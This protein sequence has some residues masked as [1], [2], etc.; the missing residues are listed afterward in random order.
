[1]HDEVERERQGLS[2]FYAAGIAAYSGNREAWAQ[3]A[4]RVQAT[5]NENPYYQWLLGARQEK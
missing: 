2:D 1:M 5:N 3:A 4:Q